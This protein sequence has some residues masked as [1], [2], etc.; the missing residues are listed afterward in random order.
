MKAEEVEGIIKVIKTQPE[1]NFNLSFKYAQIVSKLFNTPTN[2]SLARRVLINILDNWEKVDPKTREVWI[3]LFEVAGFYPY[4]SKS[5]FKLNST[6]GKIRKEY[7]KANMLGG[8]YYHEEQKMLSDLLKSDKNVIVSAPTSFGKSLLIEELVACKKYKNIVVIQPTLALLDETRKKLLR[9]KDTYKIIVRTSQRPSEEKGNVF[10]LTAE[11]VMEYKN[12]PKIEFLILDEFYKLSTKRDDE[13]SDTLNNAFYKL[14]NEHNCKFYLLGPNIDSISTGFTERYNAE[15]FKTNYN[16][17]DVEVIDMYKI[18]GTYFGERGNK[19]EYKETILFKLLLNDLANQQTIIYCSSPIRVRFLSKKFGEYLKAHGV[20]L[21]DKSLPMVDWIKENINK[22]WS[23]VDC[24][25]YGIGIHDGT[26]PKHLNAST[27]DYFNSGK[28][29]YLFCTTTIIEGVNTSAKNIVFF[30]HTKGN[31]KL[32]DFF[33]YSNIKGRAGRLMVHFTG[34]LYDFNPKISAEPIIVDIPFFEQN[35]VADEV[36]IHLEKNHVKNKE[37]IQYKKIENLSE[38]E[39]ILFRKNGVSVW[40]QKKILD[41]LDENIDQ[42]Y[43]L[44]KWNGYPNNKQLT[45]LI[46]LCWDNLLKE[47]EAERPLNRKWLTYL[48]FNYRRE[49]GIVSLINSRIKYNQKPDQTKKKNEIIDEAIKFAF[50]IQRHWLHYKVPKWIGVMNEL[51]KFVCN[52]HNLDSGEY[53]YYANQIEN[54]FVGEN[55]SILLEYGVPV[56]AVYKLQEM[57]RSDTKEDD[58]FRIIKEKKLLSRKEFTK[59]EITKI[60]ENM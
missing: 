23:L 53:T 44:I 14:L 30:D 6:A 29:N 8:K 50:Q 20:A 42:V 43:E 3:D 60:E 27:I 16:L 24:L 4:L 18:H 11:R 55:L 46:N 26:L 45:F 25:N 56:S 40:G 22:N 9:Y 59:Y 1:L 13:R 49:K 10:L 2:S 52:K 7:H 31:R 57:I 36:L 41:Y 51:Q 33:D 34:R 37:T 39:K 54:D 58:L 28:L 32:I 21:E 17:V 47:G 38:D 12:L 5:D 48:V 15:F 35:P 19:K